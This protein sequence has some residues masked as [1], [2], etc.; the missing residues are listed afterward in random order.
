[1]LVCLTVS[2][3][4]DNLVQ[5]VLDD[6]ADSSTLDDVHPILVNPQVSRDMDIVI[7]QSL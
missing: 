1:M 2:T 3:S 4:D 5:Y 7:Q 6:L